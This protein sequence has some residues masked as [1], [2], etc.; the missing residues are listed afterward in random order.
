V[1]GVVL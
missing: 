1:Y